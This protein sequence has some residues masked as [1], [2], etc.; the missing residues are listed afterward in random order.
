MKLFHVFAELVKRD[1][2]K[3]AKLLSDETGKP[4][5]EAYNE[6]RN[7]KLVFRLM[8]KELNTIMEM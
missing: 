1:E 6:V 5:K 2:D 8:S 4:L 7:F 3:L